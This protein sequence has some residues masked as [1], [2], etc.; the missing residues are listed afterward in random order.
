KYITLLLLFPFLF[1]NSVYP[2][3]DTL[4]VI[5]EKEV[6]S[7]PT[8][9]ITASELA[10]D[11]ESQD[12]SGLL[13]SSRDIF[14]S[15]AGY[16][17][18]STRFKIRGYNSENTSILINGISVNDMETGRAYWSTWGGL[19]DAT[20][21]K[22]IITGIADSRYA[23]GGV[24]GVT[25]IITRASSYRQGVKFTYSL[26]NRS[27]RDRIMFTAAT[28]LM[29]NNWAVTVSGS[30]RWANE[31]YVEG[32]FYDAW[33]YFLSVEKKINDKHS[34]GFIGFG[35][36][37]KRGKPG[38]STQEAYDL[39]GTN[40]YNPYWGYQAGEK[41]NARVNNYH[42]PWFI[43]S[44]YWDF[45]EKT[46]LTS[47][48][49]YSFGRGGSTALNWYDAPDP[50]PD[51]YKNLPSYYYDDPEYIEEY[52]EAVNNW[53]TKEGRQLQWN[54]FYF[55]NRKNLYSVVNPN[56]VEGDTLIGNLANYSVE[57]RRNDH[58]QIGLNL[59]F[60]KELNE[61]IDI[62]S[63]L[64]LTEYK[65]FR[66]KEMNDLLGGEF[67]LDIDKFAD[68]VSI[69]PTLEQNDLNHPNRIIE[70][71]DKFGYD[72]TANIN[73]YKFFAQ[74][75]FTYN[76]ID[77]YLG[78]SLSAT[79]FWR[80]GHMRNG[81]FPES[82]YGNSEKQI[83]NNYGF[84]GGLTYKI[85][86]RNF[87]TVNTAYLTLPPS[88]RTAYISPRTRDQVVDDLKSEKILSG[89][90]NYIFRSPIIKSR[91]TF[92]YT[93]FNDQTWSRSFYHDELHSFVNYMMT[94]LDKRHIG[95]EIGIE[96]KISPTVT[97]T[98]VFAKGENIY[99]SRPKVTIAQDN[100]AE[101]LAEN[102]IVY[103]ENYKVGGMP[104]SAASLGIKYN[105]PKYWYAGINVNY[106]DDIYIDINPDRRTAEAV[107]NYEPTYPP[108]WD[109]I[110][111]QEKLSGDY[112]VDF[113]GG[114]SWKINDY[115]IALNLSAN[116]VLNNQDF[117]FGGFEQ[118][119]F[120]SEETN[121]FPPK[122]FY[123]YGTTYYINLSFRF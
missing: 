79:N 34:I 117:A 92:Y 36:P 73:K 90:I 52:Q 5:S 84:K 3:K 4:S 60:N 1:I 114:K 66:Y 91:L 9:S 110:L 45:N 23:F 105:S 61:H 83:F 72:Y 96:A 89:D 109:E 112:T 59:L 87:I 98:G 44:H 55:A 24:G 74:G 88:F 71:G 8:I 85:T 78:L 108:N 16:T 6:S 13:Q 48:V 32:T 57:E 25:N 30:R 116:N 81:K 12:I 106:F 27:Y 107:A 17:F 7:V 22:E 86:G 28:G 39:A 33:A 102:R 80:T 42:K 19:N 118:L 70:V 54:D 43:L 37:S 120:D 20:R 62:S 111:D 21:N 50:R 41:R 97:L 51:Y 95:T 113:F 82:S 64:Y 40:Y 58:K 100:D 31:G 10:N 2:Q 26:C 121:K 122:Y 53:Q 11:E 18:G 63:G 123:L 75:D 29:E 101:L 76:K 69:D 46:S 115:F 93:E 104:Q 38:V 67:W 94:S 35:A 77:F 15:T 65:G 68:G 14:V 47:S 99:N 103:L 49:F 119:R 56:G